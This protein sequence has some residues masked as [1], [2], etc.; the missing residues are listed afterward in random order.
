MPN[1]KKFDVVAFSTHGSHPT[2]NR[3]FFTSVK[4]AMVGIRTGWEDSGHVRFHVFAG[5]LVVILSLVVGLTVT[6]WAVVFLLIGGIISAEIINTAIENIC[7]LLRDKAG[8]PYEFTGKAKDLASGAVLTLAF[9][10]IAIFCVI[11]IPKIIRLL[12]SL[13]LI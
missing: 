2:R 1:T 5:S 10:S 7:N 11:F 3:N 13:F 9:A 4:N 12:N 6:Q 8:V